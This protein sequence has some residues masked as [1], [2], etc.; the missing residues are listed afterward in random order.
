MT[1]SN[2][3]KQ[4]RSGK[5]S[6]ALAAVGILREKLFGRP[7]QTL[8][9]KV[10]P[11][12]AMEDKWMP[13]YCMQCGMGPCPARGHVVNGVLVK[14][15]GNPNFRDKWPCAS[16]VCAMSY[17]VMQKLYNPYRI[18]APMKRTNPQ[19]GVDED[20]KFV[21]I[22]WDEAL[23]ML[24]DKL[25]GIKEKGKVDEHGL[26]RVVQILG[27]PQAVGF[28]GHGWLPFWAAWGP[29]ESFGGGA[30]VKCT[31]TEHVFGE[32]LN[33]TFT[34]VSD[35]EW[36]NYT[37][38]FGRNVAQNTG[39]GGTAIFAGYADGKGKGMKQVVVCPSLNATAAGADEWVPIKVKT[40]AAFLLGMLHIILH[41]MEWQKVCDLD[42]LKKMTNS[43]YLIGPHGY[44]LRD[45]ATKKPLVW[46]P[47]FS[48][49]KVVHE[50]QDFA[51]D[52]TYSVNGIEIGPDEETYPADEGTP[53]FQ[54]LV[55]HVK[56]YTPEWASAVTDVPAETIRRITKEFVGHAMVGAT[57]KVD[58]VELPLRPVAI[59]LGRGVNNGWGAYPCVWASYIIQILVGALHV[60]GSIVRSKARLQQHVPFA[61]DGDGFLMADIQPTDKKNW[62]WPPKSRKGS[63]T[64]TPICGNPPLNEMPASHL[65]WK[66]FTEPMEKWPVSIP[67]A[68]ILYR[69]N[70]VT[71]QYD[72]NLIRKALEKLPFMVNFGYVIDE[73]NWYADLLLPE[74]TEL[75]S[76]QLQKVSWKETAPGWGSEYWAN[77]GSEYGGYLLRQPVVKPLFNTRDLTDILT[78]L[79]DRLE[80]MPGYN[81]N[82]NKF[83]KL[84][85][86]WALSG[87]ERY[88]AEEI[89]DRMCRSVTN[90]EYGLEWFKETGGYLWPLSKL[91]W[92]LHPYMVERGIR[93]ELPYQGRLK[94]VGEQLKRRLR[95]VGIEWWDHQADSL[96][97]ALPDWED[98]PGIYK[99]VY[100]VTPEYDMWVTSHRASVFAGQ[101]NFE[102]PWNLEVVRDYLDVPAVLVNP[103]TAK[104]KGIKDGDRVCMESVFGRTY[105][106]A[107]LSETVH[108]DV[109]SVYGFGTYKSPVSK[110]L[111]WANP[112]ELQGIDI[113]LTDELGSS[114]DQTLVKIYTVGGKK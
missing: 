34:I 31:H 90:G 94:V 89:V 48:G 73:S 83:S 104:R 71:S 87:G 74:S 101:Q 38:L 64:L 82:I 109:L 25:K 18:K 30:G 86:P 92:Y 77:W 72:S 63:K 43:P 102:V 78:E 80:M 28:G 99:T 103:Q 13:F 93:Y 3:T 15:E 91:T 23:D 29:I 44:Y 62:E 75:E 97:Q 11:E 61:P 16:L 37:I 67:D 76:Y 110:E 59:N 2:K 22:S 85:D 108:P 51:L 27:A 6:G 21:E 106:R 40:D 81:A 98:F 9:E 5:S 100:Q 57:V 54:L 84:K 95:E 105:A 10:T 7:A 111:E 20:P 88:S 114:S 68:Y 32:F 70:P 41:E 1:D 113:R 46:D 12:E 96:A 17:G 49:V 14:V 55:E 50:A 36:C 4:K 66:S 69:N 112:S 65:A 19:K 42:F 33:R 79:A 53:S 60:P 35:Y 47:S 56:E 52:G 8:M 24:A 107:Q 45:P 26:P 39:P 58:G